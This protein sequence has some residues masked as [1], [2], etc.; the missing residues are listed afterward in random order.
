MSAERIVLVKWGPGLAVGALVATAALWLV[1]LG[2][3]LAGSYTGT[4]LVLRC[5]GIAVLAVPFGWVAWRVPK[6]L[7]GMGLIVD[8]AGIHP[9]DGGVVDTIGWHEIA[10]V[11]FGSY[12]GTYR[13]MQ[14]KTM[15]GLEIYLA[16]SARVADHPRLRNDWQAVAAPTPGL[17]DGCFRYT[18]SP[19]GDAGARIEA[20]VRRHRPQQWMGP[21]LH[22]R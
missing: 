16:D 8:A 11:G 21:F 6:T 4:D 15:A 14:T 18:V 12:T 20:A 13:G 3:L 9:F 1:P 2:Y 7:R 5:L 22:A 10:A 17:S 19:Y